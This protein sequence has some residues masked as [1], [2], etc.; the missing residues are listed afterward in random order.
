MDLFVV[1]QED[2]EYSY[3]EWRIDTIFK[4]RKEAVLYAWKTAMTD[5]QGE[6]HIQHWQL[7]E[8]GSEECDTVYINVG[9]LRSEWTNEF[10][11]RLQQDV[12]SLDAGA[13]LPDVLLKYTSSKVEY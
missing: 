8:Y 5:W 9:K 12:M 4:D 7:T 11:G 3:R 13:D 2:G 6:Y 10:V 1:V